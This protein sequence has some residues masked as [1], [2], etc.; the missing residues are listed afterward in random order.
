M[1]AQWPIDRQTEFYV[2]HIIG[3]RS[4]RTGQPPASQQK[5]PGTMAEN[6]ARPARER[7]R[8]EL[9]LMAE[10]WF[11]NMEREHDYGSWAH[12]DAWNN[13]PA[14]T[15]IRRFM[16]EM[17]AGNPSAIHLYIGCSAEV[18]QN[19]DNGQLN[20]DAMSDA[21]TPRFVEQKA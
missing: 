6:R 21:R 7:A 15:K 8:R 14:S 12:I 19:Q 4:E 11:W 9:Y 2:T 18:S 10:V 3:R 5:G 16:A 1:A 13:L 20:L 17:K